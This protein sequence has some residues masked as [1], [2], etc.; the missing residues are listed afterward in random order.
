MGLNDLAKEI[1]KESVRMFGNKL[2]DKDPMVLLMLLTSEV[3]EVA[4]ETRFDRPKLYY[5]FD[6]QYGNKDDITTFPTCRSGNPNPKPEGEAAE[7][8]DVFLRLMHYVSLRGI[9]LEDA[10]EK[11]REYNINKRQWQNEGK[12]I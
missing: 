2:E 11:K 12:R 3:A 4:E 10:L 6:K 9:D 7:V 8:A 1:H 5:K